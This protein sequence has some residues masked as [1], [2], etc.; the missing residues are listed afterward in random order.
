M[1]KVTE[2]LLNIY[3]WLAIMFFVIAGVAVLFIRNYMPFVLGLTFGIIISALNFLQL[4]LTLKK[5]VQ[6]TPKRAHT[7]AAMHYYIRFI[8]YGVVIYVSIKVP[9]INVLGT[10][11]GLLLIKVVIYFT[12]LFNN[13]EYFSKIFESKRKEED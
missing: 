4:A 11:I 2:L 10:I 13:K 9:N 8:I 1:Y 6:M 12:N 7:Y 3:K 5:S